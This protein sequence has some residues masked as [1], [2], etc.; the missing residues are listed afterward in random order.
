MALKKSVDSPFGVAFEYW[1]V[2][3]DMGVDFAERSARARLLVW[4]D[5]T[6]RGA[7]KQPQH[8][9][10]VVASQALFRPVEEALIL[11]GDDFTAALATGDLRAAIYDKIKVLDFFDG[12]E[13]LL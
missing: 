13:D 6:A 12:S 11:S 5:A 2:M 7:D 4:A 1:K 10:E 3:P 8:P 9:N